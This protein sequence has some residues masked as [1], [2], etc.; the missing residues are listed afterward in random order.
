M[1]LVIVL[2]TM[3]LGLLSS[4]AMGQPLNGNLITNLLTITPSTA[5]SGET[6][7]LTWSVSS[8]GI[9][10]GRSEVVTYDVL[11]DSVVQY[12][13]QPLRII[14][15]G[16]TSNFSDTLTMP[17]VVSATSYQITVRVSGDTGFNQNDNSASRFVTVTTPP[18]PELHCNQ[19]TGWAGPIV[20]SNVLNATTTPSLIPFGVTV[21][22]NYSLINTGGTTPAG[23]PV[24]VLLDNVSV[25]APTPYPPMTT[26]GTNGE[27]NF[28]LPAGRLTPGQH[29]LILQIDS[30]H[31]VPESNENNNDCGLFFTIA[32]PPRPNLAFDPPTARITPAVIVSNQAGASSSANSMNQGDT[33]FVSVQYMNTGTAASAAFTVELRM[34]NV[35]VG[36]FREGGLAVGQSVTH[37]D[38]FT[39][40]NIP[41]GSVPFKVTLDSGNEITESDESDNIRS[42]TIQ[43]NPSI[44]PL[45]TSQPTTRVICPSSSASFNVAASGSATLSYQWQIED[46]TVAGGWRTISNGALVGPGGMTNYT[47]T[48]AQTPTLNLTAGPT[49]C[50]G[51][52]VNRFR[53]R[54]S[55]LC[56]GVFSDAVSLY[57]APADLGQQGGLPG[58]DQLYD[59]NDFVVFIDRFFAQDP[60]A[61]IGI[62]GGLLGSDGLWDNNDF[63]VFINQFFADC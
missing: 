8:Q 24:V 27:R 60:I 28:V 40:P 6:V 15:N 7:T 57:F 49:C 32:D 42:V 14:N 58:R 36:G 2:I 4:T 1:R 62:Q 22:A 47:V 20:V 18:Q 52:D 50:D 34:N 25:N 45:V 56:G 37:V 54:V 53:A 33:A 41:A 59:N 30:I 3:C 12:T 44:C 46:A 48:G 39:V 43:V 19:P 9:A 16:T 5:S 35:M 13:R 26:G 51:S 29:Q 55:N 38:L 17:N 61:D 63:V 23:V 10:G 11:R 31:A 21:Y